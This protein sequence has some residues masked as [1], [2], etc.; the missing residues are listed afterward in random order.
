MARPTVSPPERGALLYEG[1]AKRVFATSDEDV[2]IFEYKDDATAFN[3]EK[4]ERFLGK[5]ALNNR[6]SSL[7]FEAVSARGV[8]THFVARLTER[9]QVCR[10]VEI[11]PLE[12]VVRNRIAGSMARR[13]GVTEGAT[14]SVP[15]VE[16]CY[17]RDDLGDPVLSTGHAVALSLATYADIAWM[18]RSAL[19]VNI[20]LGA[21]FSEVGIELVDF[22]LEFGRL[23][24]R[25]LL[26]DEISPDTCRLW[27]IATG[28]RFDKDRFRRDLAPLLDGYREV[29]ARLERTTT[30]DA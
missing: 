30:R 3:G 5:G 13:Y 21:I 8:P 12:V 25:L 6:L 27:D 2:V 18:E 7:L 1:K 11:V 4:H 19:Q 15:I 28:E 17:K 14:L 9:E 23:D 16:L 29:L 20:V 24:G 26:A 10:R 22:K